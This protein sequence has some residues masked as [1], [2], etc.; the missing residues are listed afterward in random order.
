MRPTRNYGLAE[1]RILVTIK[2]LAAMLGCGAS[3]ARKIGL[4]AK[5]H[6][7]I[8]SRSLWNIEKVNEYVDSISK[9]E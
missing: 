3:T 1:G 6:V 8:G 9:S 5:A 4:E 7:K 2:E